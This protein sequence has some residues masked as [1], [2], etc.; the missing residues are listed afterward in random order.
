MQKMTISY[1]FIT[2]MQGK[3][4]LKLNVESITFKTNNTQVHQKI[5]QREMA[6]HSKDIY[7]TMNSCLK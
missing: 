6:S 5:L 1:G 3:V 2:L 7:L 4:L